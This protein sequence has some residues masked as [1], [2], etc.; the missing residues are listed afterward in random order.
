[1]DLASIKHL[2]TSL[3]SQFQQCDS[4]LELRTGSY[5]L[6]QRALDLEPP[7]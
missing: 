5:S 2:E 7:Q 1:M 4:P 6:V 3:L